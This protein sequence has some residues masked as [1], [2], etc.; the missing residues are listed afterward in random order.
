[1]IDFHTHILPGID[2]GSKSVDESIRMLREEAKLGIKEVVLT[3][4]FYASENSPQ[5]FLRRRDKAW[6]E[7]QPRLTERLP[8][9]RLGAE[10][11][12]YEGICRNADLKLLQIEGTGLLL[13]E[14]P[15]CRWTNR[16]IEDVLTLNDRQGTRVVLAHIERYLPMQ[17]R[18]TIRTMIQSEVLL[19]SNVS[20]FCQWRTRRKA[21][22]M[23][24]RG[25]I[26]FVGSDCHNMTTRRP[27]WDQLPDKA[28]QGML[29][30]QASALH[31]YF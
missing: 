20:F 26:R 21:L 29:A 4:H 15:M 2:D 5:G 11:Y 22:S 30:I 14:M 12:Y 3:P 13:L 1:M 18:D 16:M 23:L 27:N 28:K 19:Q 9:L 31:S 25:E 24:C 17:E 10:V 7:L 8:R 6:K